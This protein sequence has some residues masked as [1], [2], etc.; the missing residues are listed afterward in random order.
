MYLTA[1]FTM[2][3][4]AHAYLSFNQP[5]WLVG[6]LIS[7][8]IKG[9]KKFDFSPRIQQGIML[10]RAIDGFTDSHAATA[11]AKTVFKPAYRLYSGAFVDVVYD[12][13]L[14][15]DPQI[16]AT[17]TDL[18]RF[19]QSVYT[20][21]FSSFL[22]VPENLHPFFTRM[23]AQNWLYNYRLPYGI[24]KSFGGLVYRSQY[25]T[26][27]LPA[28]QIFETH[29]DFLKQCYRQFF[30]DLLAFATMYVATN[31]QHKPL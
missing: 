2:N 9:K 19:T 11:E 5:D 30:P 26:D 3:Y 4:L 22:H 10:H 17:E 24:E 12:H 29:Y 23:K 28:L 20:D 25:L 15:T 8:F 21:I 1:F 18:D 13:F 16:F 14:A 6:N 7:D 31:F 27:A